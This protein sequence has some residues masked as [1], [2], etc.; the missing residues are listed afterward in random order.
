MSWT[1]AD[2]EAVE[3]A[4][5]ADAEARDMIPATSI[6]DEAV[7]EIVGA[8]E[9]ARPIV[10]EEIEEVTPEI[11]WGPEHELLALAILSQRIE[12]RTKILRPVVGSSYGDGDKHSYRS[13]LGGKLGTIW[14]TDPDYRWTV[15]DPGAMAEWLRA[16]S[17]DDAFETVYVLH[18]PNVTTELRAEDEL[19]IVLR[20]HAPHLL[21]EWVRIKPSVIAEEIR[22]AKEH[23]WSPVAGMVRTKPGGVFTVKPD[24]NGQAEVERLVQARIIDGTG[25]RMLTSG[26][27]HDSNARVG[28]DAGTDQPGAQEAEQE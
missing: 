8:D 4:D 14:R 1:E 10:V 18:T 23:D 27:D 15:S 22:L 20:E 12:G 25:R 9:P 11:E 5:Q 3:R 28:A 21:Q 24:K 13:P 16:K 2:R 7:Y 26:G 17:R 6:M 19:C